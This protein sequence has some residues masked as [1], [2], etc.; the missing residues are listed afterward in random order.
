[1]I[2]RKFKKLKEKKIIITAVFVLAAIT[3]FSLSFYYFRR[4]N[5]IPGLRQPPIMTT[6]TPALTPLP[7]SPY[8]TD[9][10]ILQIQD[11]LKTL[12]KSLNT[13]KF[14]E[15]QLLPPVLDFEVEL[16]E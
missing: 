11:E 8:A 7:K 5:Q 12:E 9:A 13:I 6:P 10:A 16:K 15:S 14:R 4:I 1:M 2:F 3:S